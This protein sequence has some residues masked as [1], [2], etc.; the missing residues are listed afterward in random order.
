[1]R[2]VTC[3]TDHEINRFLI[4]DFRLRGLEPFPS[5]VED[6]GQSLITGTEF[7]DVR[8]HKG[9]AQLPYYLLKVANYLRRFWWLLKR[10]E[11]IPP[12][13]RLLADPNS[14]TAGA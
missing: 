5:H 3:A 4:H 2:R 8:K 14:Q 7:A 13:R 12:A 6:R 11:M 10:G 1:M 9:L